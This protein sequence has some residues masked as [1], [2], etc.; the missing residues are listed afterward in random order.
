MTLAPSRRQLLNGNRALFLV[1]I[2]ITSLFISCGSSKD[3]LASTRTRPTKKK[4]KRAPKNAKIDIINWTVI[5][6]KT[7]PPINE[8][9]KVSSV[10]KD[11]YNVSLFLPFNAER[12]SSLND[13]KKDAKAN[14]FV[15][16]YAG[17]LLGLKDLDKD[18][19]RL[20]VNVEDSEAAGTNFHSQLRSN[21]ARSADVIIG[22]YD[23]E[24]LK[25]VAQHG[26]DNKIPVIS[27]WQARKSI[28]SENP[29]Y[30]NLR[31]FLS[32]HYH[33]IT[34]HIVEHFD[35][36]QVYLVGRDHNTKDHGRFRYFQSHLHNEL[37]RPDERFNELSVSTDS[38]MTGVFAF[39]QIFKKNRT[40][41]LIIPNWM[42]ADEEFIYQ[43][44]RRIR[45]EKGLNDVVVYLMP[46]MFESN[47]L[48]YDYYK[49]LNLRIV[50]SKFVNIKDGEVRDFRRNFYSMYDAFPTAD[51]YDG[52]DMIRFV[53]QG[54][55]KY[56]KNFHQEFEGHEFQ[57]LQTK[58]KVIPES[59]DS[60][61]GPGAR[62]VTNYYINDYYLDI[63]GFDGNGFSRI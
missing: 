52:Y 53:G 41:V 39:Q 5:D 14:K 22:P 44:L 36:D 54:L 6:E 60:D 37:D 45:V 26:I 25:L 28:T 34:D 48:D 59:I 23:K 21:D 55:Q 4:P 49:N 31:P 12:T 61:S 38:L 10:M 19:I 15:N 30:I 40:T 8:S 33:R 63:I 17:V 35:T 2:I 13:I 62:E 46:L 58:Y 47:R 27:P 42:G 32:S 7:H 1:F 3:T 50:R 9:T 43:C 11:I 51:A 29:Y 20:N 16:Y 24:N 57:G 18:G 56:G